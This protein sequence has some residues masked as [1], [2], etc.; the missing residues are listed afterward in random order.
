[1]TRR[2]DNPFLVD[3]AH[4]SRPSRREFMRVGFVTGLGLSLGDFLRLERAAADQPKIGGENGPRKIEPRAQSIIYIFLQGGMS[5]IETFDP[6]PNAPIEYRGQLGTV[7]TKTGDVFGGLMRQTAGIADKIAVIRSFTHTEAAHERGT[8]NMLTGYQPSPVIDY[9]SLGSVVSHEFGPRKNLPPYC[10]VPGASDPYL[11]TGY[12]SSAF[13]PFS[14]GGEPNNNNFQVRDLSLPK[15]VDAERMKTRRSLREAVDSHFAD[16]EKS[17]ALDAMDEFYQRAYALISAP[18]A[19]EAFNIRKEPD[20]IRNEYGRTGI[21]QRLLLA[22]RLVEAGVRFVTVL[23]GGWDMHIGIDGG[24]RGRLPPLDQGYA[25]LIRD[26]DRRGLLDSTL[27]VMTTEFGRT[28]KINKDQGRDHWPKVFSIA[29]AGG[30]I[31]GGVIHGMS[32]ALGA[33]PFD[34]PVGP[35]DMAATIFTQLGIPPEK[36]L[37]APG[38]RP[39]EIVRDGKPIADLL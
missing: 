3:P 18:E 5:H 11:G 35:A 6:K 27:V 38:P 16:L 31:K 12:L 22:R 15:G 4:F 13:G 24:M 20:K 32:D 25:A 37:L 10:C 39:I 7:K 21:G 17:D 34:K 36:E 2:R 33:E 23:E 8:H 9:P 28:P 19:R 26:L 30:G 1:M 14:I 29:M